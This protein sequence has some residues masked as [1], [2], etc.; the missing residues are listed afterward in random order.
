MSLVPYSSD[1]FRGPV[2][3]LSV[4]VLILLVVSDVGYPVPA[5]S[6]LKKVVPTDV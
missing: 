3:T 5:D 1:K 6:A 4:A 2:L